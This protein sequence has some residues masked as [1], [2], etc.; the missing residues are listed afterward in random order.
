MTHVYVS[1]IIYLYILIRRR[2]LRT[3]LGPLRKESTLRKL[4]IGPSIYSPFSENLPRVLGLGYPRNNRR[5]C[6]SFYKV[7]EE[8][9]Q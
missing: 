2:N 9:K 1:S 4:K 3:L 6:F 8:K 7:K 5:S